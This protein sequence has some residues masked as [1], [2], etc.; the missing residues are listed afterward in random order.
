MRLLRDLPWE[1]PCGGDCGDLVAYDLSP[2]CN[3]APFVVRCTHADLRPRQSMFLRFSTSRPQRRATVATR[4]RQASPLVSQPSMTRRGL[5]RSQWA[6][7]WWSPP[8]PGRGKGT[9][10]AHCQFGAQRE[11]VIFLQK[12]IPT[13]ATPAPSGVVMTGRCWRACSRLVI[14]RV[15]S[16]PSLIVRCWGVPAVAPA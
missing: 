2:I 11:P 7:S 8:T 10:W 12:T 15:R 6:T 1:W 4:L 3:V 14:A 9:G 16:G 13:T 5:G